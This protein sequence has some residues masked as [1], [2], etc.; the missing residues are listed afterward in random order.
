MVNMRTRSLFVVLVLLA[1]V[2]RL[3]AIDHTIDTIP[4]PRVMHG[5]FLS[6]PDELVPPGEARE[7]NDLLIDL[8]KKTGVEYAVVIVNSIGVENPK[9]FA[10]SLFNTWKIGKK[11]KDNGLLLLIVLGQRRWEFET[12]Y[13]LEGILPDAKLKRIGEGHLPAHFRNKAFGKGILEASR[14]VIGV[15]E[16][17]VNEVGTTGTGQKTREPDQYD[18]D[19]W[20]PENPKVQK[21]SFIATGV[22]VAIYLVAAAAILFW[23]IRIGSKGPSKGKDGIIDAGRIPV[24]LLIV[25]LTGLIVP[26]V[27]LTG[28]LIAPTIRAWVREVYYGRLEGLI[29][30]VPYTL[31]G[32][33]VLHGRL[34]KTSFVLNSEKHPHKAYNALAQ[35]HQGTWFAAIL[36]PLFYAFYGIY[37]FFT[38]RRLRSAPRSCGKC[39]KEMSR[40][41]EKKDDVYLQKGQVMEENLGSVDYDVWYCRSCENTSVEPYDAIWTSYEKCSKCH[42]KTAYVTGSRT[43]TSPTYT[44]T[45]TGS[46]DHLCKHCGHAWVTS[47]TIPMLVRSSSSSSGGSSSG[48]SSSSSSSSSGGSSFGGGSSGGGGAGGSW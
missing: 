20:D 29:I 21:R 10:T 37:I 19:E 22:V 6:D 3:S 16:A 42:Y 15:V 35:S 40:L 11:E 47:Y 44:S 48:G 13:G 8:E 34:R 27:I 1:A 4:N 14:A 41:D 38:R 26:I 45:G 33:A 36:F 24:W 28:D 32:L 7:I 5:G 30:V 25:I 18:Y 43:V 23:R 12:G 2:G 9:E 46:R 17:N 31:I 39:S